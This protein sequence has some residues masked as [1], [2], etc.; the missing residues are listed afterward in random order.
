MKVIPDT[1]RT[2]WRLYQTRVVRD[3]GYTRHVSYVMKVIPDTC[4]TWWR[5]YQTRV[6]GDEGYTRH[7]SCVMKIIPD[8]CRAWWR[9]YRKGVVRTNLDNYV[10]FVKENHFLVCKNLTTHQLNIA[11]SIKCKICIRSPIPTT[12]SANISW[13]PSLAARSWPICSL[14][15][16]GLA[17]LM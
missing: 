12:L 5:L 8:T 4:R 2:W 15:Y 11:T 17:S 7:M 1:C 6:V 13:H 16:C 10:F 9:L 14:W 3:E